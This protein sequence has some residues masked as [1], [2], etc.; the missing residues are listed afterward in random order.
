MIIF[1]DDGTYDVFADD[2]ELL[3]RGSDYDWA[4]QLWEFKS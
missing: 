4:L 3:Y 2:G 1:N